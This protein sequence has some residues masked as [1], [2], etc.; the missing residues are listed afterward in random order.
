MFNV[1]LV[2]EHPKLMPFRCPSHPTPA[3]ATNIPAIGTSYVLNRLVSYSEQDVERRN[4]YFFALT[5]NDR[6]TSILWI[7]TCCSAYEP[8]S[9]S[10]IKAIIIIS[11]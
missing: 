4:S 2:M 7:D 3:C 11:L 8:S 6:T 1:V 9:Q 10:H 5:P